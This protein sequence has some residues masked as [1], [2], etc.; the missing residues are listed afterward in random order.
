MSPERETDIT[1]TSKIGCIHRQTVVHHTDSEPT[2]AYR[3][4]PRTQ[5]I[6]LYLK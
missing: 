2:S 4:L 3:V 6:L 1:I 5:S